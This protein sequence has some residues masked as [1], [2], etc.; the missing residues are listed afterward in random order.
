MSTS[1]EQ[2]LAE[3][4]IGYDT[5]TEEGIKLCAGFVKGWLDSRE[6]ESN[7]LDIRGLPGD[8][9]DGRPRRGPDR[10]AARPS[11]RRPRAARSSSSRGST[12]TASTAAAPT[13]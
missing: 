1:E 13:T 3:K 4:L 5:S 10:P 12:A 9:R 8:H 6:V 7:Q 11:R 2:A